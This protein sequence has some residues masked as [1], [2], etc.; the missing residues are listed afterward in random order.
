VTYTPADVIKVNVSVTG[1]FGKP[2]VTPVFG[3]TDGENVTSVRETVK[4]GVNQAVGNVMDTG[5]EKLRKEAEAQGDQL[6][7]KQKSEDSSYGMK[8][9][10]QLRQ[11]VKKL[12]CRPEAYYRC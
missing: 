7:R 11:Y 12:T 4:E 9:Q 5:K 3:S 8:L 10:R 6:I 2:V 1:V